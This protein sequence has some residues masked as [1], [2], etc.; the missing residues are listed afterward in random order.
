MA[1]ADLFKAALRSGGDIKKEH[2]PIG[3]RL[4]D[5]TIFTVEPKQTV[6]AIVV[7]V[8]KSEIRRD[9]IARMAREVIS[10][11]VLAVQEIACRLGEHMADTEVILSSIAEGYSSD[12]SDE[13]KN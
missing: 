3:D 10:R 9:Q 11:N 6:G 2:Y 8:T 1:C 4:F 12:D 5:L 7:D 13:N